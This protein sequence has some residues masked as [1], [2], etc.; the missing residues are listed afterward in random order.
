[1][2]F[3]KKQY[4]ELLKIDGFPSGWEVL[5][6]PSGRGRSGVRKIGDFPAFGEVAPGRAGL[7]PNGWR[8]EAWLAADQALSIRIR[9]RFMFMAVATN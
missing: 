7:L 1:M 5:R 6:G 4:R 8:R 3:R 9:A 2:Y